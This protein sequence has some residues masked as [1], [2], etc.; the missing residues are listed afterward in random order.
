MST[1]GF[2]TQKSGTMKEGLIKRLKDNAMPEK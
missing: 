2:Q 1:V